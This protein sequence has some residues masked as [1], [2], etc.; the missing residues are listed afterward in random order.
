MVK[1]EQSA[2]LK[3][4]A[5]RVVGIVIDAGI[6]GA[7]YL[8]AVVIRF[9]FHEPTWG[10]RKTALCYISVC[11]AHLVSLLLTGCYRLAWRRISVY[12]LPRY[13]AATALAALVLTGLRILLPV[14]TFAHVRPPYSITVIAF[15]LATIGVVGVR[16]L[17]RLWWAGRVRESEL[18]ERDE[19]TFDNSVAARFFAGKTVMV[20]GAGGSIGSEIVRQVAAAG[21]KRVL[22]VE[23]CE[24][25][26]YEIN[27]RVPGCVPLMKD[28]NDRAEME[29]IF[30]AERPEV[31]LHAAAYKHVP[32]VEMNPEEGWRNNTEG[33]KTLVELAAAHGVKRFVMISTDKAVNPVSV[34]GKTKLAAEEV[35]LANGFCAVRFGNV[36]GSSGSVV[37]LFREQIRRGGPVTVTHP[38]MKRYFMTVAEA[39][40]LVLQAASRSESA[41]YTLDM[42]K[43]VKIVDLAENMIEQAGFRP[44][45]DI[46]IVFTGI[47]PGEKLFEEIDISE[48]NAYK[49]DMAKIYITKAL[50]LFVT[51]AC[52][53]DDETAA[54]GEGFDKY[55]PIIDR[56]MFGQPPAGFDPTK[57]PSEV[58]ATASRDQNKP[59]TPEQQQLQKAINFSVL[60]LEP[61]GRAIVG[62]SDKTNPKAPH[63]FYLHVGESSRGWTV[64]EADAIAGTVKLRK[65]PEGD[66]AQAEPIE[67]EMTLGDKSASTTVAAAKGEPAAGAVPALSRRGRRARERD[68]ATREEIRKQLEEERRRDEEK[69]AAEKVV[70]DQQREEMR[71]QLVNLQDQLRSTLEANKKAAEE[72]KAEEEAQP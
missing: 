59:L 9:D 60:N 71:A 26:L 29:R 34:M 56:A 43:P 4:L 24:N 54:N 70:R 51:L 39:V 32:M 17:W 6:I 41:I 27:R 47:R 69:E 52:I 1:R 16:M 22:L 31:V 48:K 65:D 21:A 37:P 19:R 15:V 30:A 23:R 53:A 42:G 46:P 67:L 49:T 25:A 66:S 55:Q 33:T 36:L 13:C 3:F 11:A 45:V 38:D 40:S 18:I 20:T 50:A 44:Y 5:T 7:A 28:I 57:S 72:E 14:D 35:V 62:F 12:E 10:W 58:K 63:Y 64:L 68:A 8:A 61:D 2:W